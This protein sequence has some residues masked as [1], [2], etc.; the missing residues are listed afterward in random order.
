MEARHRIAGG[1]GE[2]HGEVQLIA[3]KH[4]ERAAAVDVQIADI[5]GEMR[6]FRGRAQLGGT[7][8]G[9]NECESGQESGGEALLRHAANFTAA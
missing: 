8:A 5:D 6:G 7:T 9:G 4:S 2:A 1:V 3:R